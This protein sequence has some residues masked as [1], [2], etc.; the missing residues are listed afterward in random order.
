MA[1]PGAASIGHRVRM[2]LRLSY[3]APRADGAGFQEASRRFH[4]RVRR[5]FHAVP[6]TRY[7]REWMA[8]A[9]RPPRAAP[10]GSLAAGLVVADLFEEP[11]CGARRR[12]G[13]GASAYSCGP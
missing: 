11:L 10:G 6:K 4:R 3:G 12:R 8:H 1:A 7:R 5:G 2:V 9:T 13:T